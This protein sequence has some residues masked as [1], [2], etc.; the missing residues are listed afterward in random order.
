MNRDVEFIKPHEI[1]V[2]I[3]L[4]GLNMVL[5]VSDIKIEKDSINLDG[6]AIASAWRELLP[7]FDGES[8][9]ERKLRSELVKWIATKVK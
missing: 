7:H 4:G 3:R 1:E 9:Q 2:Q 5:Y 6:L 8:H